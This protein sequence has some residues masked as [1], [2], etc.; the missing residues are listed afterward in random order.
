MQLVVVSSG[1]T[2]YT[3]EVPDAGATVHD[4][5]VAFGR[6]TGIEVAAQRLLFKGRARQDGEVLAS[7]GVVAGAC[8]RRHR[9]A[10]P[11]PSVRASLIHARSPSPGAAASR[12]SAADHGDDAVSG[13]HAAA[14]RARGQGRRAGCTQRVR[15]R[16]R[17][18]LG[19]SGRARRAA[20]ARAAAATRM[21]LDDQAAAAR[22]VPLTGAVW[23]CGKEPPARTLYARPRPL[24]SA[25]LRVA[26]AQ[27]TSRAPVLGVCCGTPRGRRAGWCLDRGVVLSALV[28]GVL[29]NLIII[30]PIDNRQVEVQSTAV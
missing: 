20:D 29:A 2:Q 6:Q 11:R 12:Q 23:A 3:V 7:L 27:R 1:E 16:P 18:S 14:G 30:S 19:V 26:P 17:A 28:V 24:H 13:V 22:R 8:A 9:P 4:A 15:R 10:L 5:K 21:R 25:V